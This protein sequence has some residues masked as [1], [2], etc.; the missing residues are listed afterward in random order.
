MAKTTKTST[1]SSSTGMK[2][3]TDTHNLGNGYVPD[4][5]WSYGGNVQSSRAKS[6]GKM[7]G[8]RSRKGKMKY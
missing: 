8:H 6:W 5:K 2:S 4:K 3:L 7:S 1:S